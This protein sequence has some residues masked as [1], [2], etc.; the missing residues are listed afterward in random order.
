MRDVPTDSHAAAVA[1]TPSL[2]VDADGF[3]WIT[4]DEPDST[5]N[6]LTEPV[7]RRL[8]SALDEVRAGAR[9]GRVRAVIIRSGKESSFIAGADVD[10]VASLEDPQ[11]AEAKVKLGQAVFGDAFYRRG[12][13]RPGSRG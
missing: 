10:V 1:P 7:M 3:G 6:V 4:F 13:E 12:A 11:D 5:H 2:R 8:G 9:E